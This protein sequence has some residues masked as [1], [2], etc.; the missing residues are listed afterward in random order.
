MSEV[1]EHF[2]RL[3]QRLLE[4]QYMELA[5]NVFKLIPMKMEKFYELFDKECMEIPVFKYYDPYQL[6]QRLSC[7]SNEDIVRIK[8]KLLARA[9]KTNK[10][11][12]QPEI[13]NIVT[14]KKIIDEYIFGKS[15]TIK[16]VMLTDFSNELGTILQKF[17]VDTSE[18]KPNYNIFQN[19]QRLNNPEEPQWQEQ[20]NIEQPQWQDTNY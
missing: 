14:F 4:K 9:E 1:L 19:V 8:E 2:N 18:V 17:G 15:P 7:G 10:E 16:L 5:E 12:L 6:F 13:D 3:N 11:L 20:N